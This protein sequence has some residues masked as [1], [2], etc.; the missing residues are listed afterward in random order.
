MLIR[1]CCFNRTVVGCEGLRHAAK[2]AR[3]APAL[4]DH[5]NPDLM[6]NM[7]ET[8]TTTS[9]PKL[10]RTLAAIRVT[11]AD[12]LTLLQG[13]LTQDMNEL[14]PDKP[15]LAGWTNPKGRLICLC[16]LLDWDNA[17]WLLVPAELRDR[18]S[19]R[20]KMYVLRAEV[21]VE[22]SELPV[23]PADQDSLSGLSELNNKPDISS[24]DS[25][26]YNDSL[27]F[28]K[29]AGLVVGGATSPVETASWRLA[30]IRAGL[31]SIWPE[32]YE[33]FIPQMLNLDLLG[34]ISFSKGC[35]V[36]QEIIARTQNLGRIKRRMYRF[37]TT[38]GG[39]IL[40]GD[41]VFA[42]DGTTAGTVVDAIATETASELLAVIR[43][44]MLPHALSLGED[45]SLA[46]TPETL[47]YNVPETI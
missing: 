7:P 33:L 16:W 32:T 2:C 23:E 4:H 24:I 41:P 1:V 37:R 45:G 20:L 28:L 34:A 25:C 40:P 31:P 21:Q 12:R 43:I 3:M 35:Y 47:P 14:A 9:V 29:Q 13:Q 36:G 15:L 10:N 18:I 6:K 39:Y 11:G 5:G 19:Q 44:E 27:F 30:N 22:N 46:L 38:T 26:F 42:E 8:N 17:V